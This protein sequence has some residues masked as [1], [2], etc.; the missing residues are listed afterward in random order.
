MGEAER[1]VLAAEAGG[2]GR[3]ALR[4]AARRR[5]ATADVEA[6]AELVE[7]L[8]AAADERRAGD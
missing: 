2:E 4:R 1:E 5:R 8:V 3:E 7:A 6:E